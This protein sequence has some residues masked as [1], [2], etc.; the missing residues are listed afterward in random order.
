MAGACGKPVGSKKKPRPRRR[1]PAIREQRTEGI[2]AA[3]RSYSEKP[4]TAMAAA[5]VL[6]PA[7]L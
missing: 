3:G 4:P 7:T 6:L 2:G 1:G 5:C